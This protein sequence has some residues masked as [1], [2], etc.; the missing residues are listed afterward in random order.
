ML[1]ASSEF[2]ASKNEE[3][4]PTPA[5]PVFANTITDN[6][7]NANKHTLFVNNFA[8]SNKKTTNVPLSDIDNQRLLIRTSLFFALLA[9]TGLAL[10]LNGLISKIMY[11]LSQKRPIGMKSIYQLFSIS[12]ILCDDFSL[13]S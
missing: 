4:G 10:F 3:S 9:S 8:D 2:L 7:D 6:F 12:L 11:F 1:V 13:S 5:L